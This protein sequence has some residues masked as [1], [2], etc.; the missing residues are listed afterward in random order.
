MA[1]SYSGDPSMSAKD[2]VRFLIQDTDASDPL[3]SDEEILY[4]LGGA[5]GALVA[6]AHVAG[7]LAFRFARAC[8]TSIGDYSV[9]LSS[10]AERYR[11]LAK[12]LESEAHMASAIPY[13]GGISRAD[14]RMREQ[15][16]DRTEPAFARGMLESND[17]D[18]SHDG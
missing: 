12:K 14:K 18:E 1:W 4:A 9:S 13:A 3:V 5:G 8:D 15:D 16:S 2:E 7:V 11:L 6:A 10:V 17:A